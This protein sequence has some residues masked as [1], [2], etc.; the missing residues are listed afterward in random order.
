MLAHRMQGREEIEWKDRSWRLQHN[1]T[2]VAYDDWNCGGVLA[3]LGGV[4]LSGAWRSAGWRG[5][6]GA[7]GAGSVLATVGYVTWTYGIKG[8]QQKEPVSDGLG[9]VNG[10]QE[11]MSDRHREGGM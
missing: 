4:A 2:Q 10:S 1:E 11:L 6:V 8:G 9:L 3:G 7:A 5:A